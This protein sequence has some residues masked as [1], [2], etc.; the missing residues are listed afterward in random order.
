MQEG[1]RLAAEFLSV[2]Y[3]KDCHY[4]DHR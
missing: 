4:L 2:D 3:Y 1:E